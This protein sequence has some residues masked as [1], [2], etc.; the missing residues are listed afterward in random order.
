MN[1]DPARHLINSW[2]FFYQLLVAVGYQSNDK[3]ISAA[4]EFSSN[5]KTRLDS[6]V[7]VALSCKNVSTGISKCRLSLI[8]NLFFF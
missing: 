3:P 5:T 8:C 4:S 1:G 6:F 2:T 7:M